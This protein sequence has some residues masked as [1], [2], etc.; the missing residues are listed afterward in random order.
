MTSWNENW[1]VYS[2]II[3][4]ITHR[5]F[6]TGPER[7]LSSCWVA[8]AVGDPCLPQIHPMNFGNNI[9]FW[10]WRHDQGIPDGR[11]NVPNHLCMLVI[12]RPVLN[13]LQ[14]W[15]KSLSAPCPKKGKTTQMPSPMW[16]KKIGPK[17]STAKTTYHLED[18][19]S[20]YGIGFLAFY[21]TF[22]LAHLVILSI[23][24]DILSDIFSDILS[25]I[26]SGIHSGP[27][28]LTYIL[29]FSLAIS[30]GNFTWHSFWQVFWHPFWHVCASGCAAVGLAIGLRSVR[31]GLAMS[32]WS[33]AAP[34]ELAL[35]EDPGSI[36]AEAGEK[37]ARRN[38]GVGEGV[39][40]FQLVQIWRPLT[41]HAG[42][43]FDARCFAAVLPK[44]SRCAQL[45]S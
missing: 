2:P 24:S 21:L 41:W 11:W 14:L 45:C 1:V 32:F 36:G 40:F 29:M 34:L 31:A 3:T 15:K 27:L 18:S 30:Y 7:T 17:E 19:G 37:E 44:L 13:W 4:P 43:K 5:N 22:F 6:R 42:N 39:A 26:F 8:W 10:K 25:G 9:C 12:L 16:A 35:A 20:I 28:Y 33:E 38:D 23:Y